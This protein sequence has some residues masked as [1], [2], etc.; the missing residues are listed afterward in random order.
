[1]VDP[2][3]AMDS[4]YG[5]ATI[6]HAVK[7]VNASGSAACRAERKLDDAAISAKL[8]ELF[9]RSA[10]ISAHY[11]RIIM[12]TPEYAEAFD[13]AIGRGAFETWQ[14]YLK[15]AD[16]KPYYALSR[17]MRL[18]DMIEDVAF[19]IS[20]AL[21][22]ERI[23]LKEPLSVL[24]SGNGAMLAKSIEVETAVL[25]AMERWR[26]TH[27]ALDLDKFDEIQLQVAMAKF[28]VIETPMRS[29]EL[30]VWL[31][32]G[33]HQFAPGAVTVFTSLCVGPQ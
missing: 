8:R 20:K 4:D 7:I 10:T 1:M 21:V 17:P 32:M 3:E 15:M 23:D 25:E 5:R 30:K 14:A 26:K 27:P 9:I 31:T 11:D 12:Q 24:A 29:P 22:I 33:P 2:S 6:D 19:T 16:L 18:R 13:L 28:K